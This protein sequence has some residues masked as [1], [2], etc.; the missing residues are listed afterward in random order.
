VRPVHHEAAGFAEHAFALMVRPTFQDVHGVR[1]SRRSQH[2][3]HESGQVEVGV[4]LPPGSRRKCGRREGKAR[5][6]VGAPLLE[7]VVER[8]ESFYLES[9]VANL[10]VDVHPAQAHQI[11]VVLLALSRSF[12]DISQPVENGP[13]IRGKH[14]VLE[15]RRAVRGSDGRV[16][17]NIPL[18]WCHQALLVPASGRLS[19]FAIWSRV[20][21]LVTD[22]GSPPERD[23]LSYSPRSRTRAVPPPYSDAGITSSKSA[24]SSG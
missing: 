16:W 3:A 17:V 24:Y 23:R 7:T 8:D 19:S 18:S 22:A 12:K 4:G 20:R 15:A 5:R 2:P 14:A 11:D 10:E 21:S 1:R 9:S 13:E 6:G